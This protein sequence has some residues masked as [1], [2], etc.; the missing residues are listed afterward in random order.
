MTITTVMVCVVYSFLSL[1]TP[2]KRILWSISHL[3]F[4]HLLIRINNNIRI[5]YRVVFT[6]QTIRDILSDIKKKKSGESNGFLKTCLVVV[7]MVVVVTGVMRRRVSLNTARVRFNPVNLARKKMNYF[8]MGNNNS[9]RPRRLQQNIL[10]FPKRKCVYTV[11]EISID[12]VHKS[13]L[14]FITV[15]YTTHIRIVYIIYIHIYTCKI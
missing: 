13:V 5:I 14:F 1:F 8:V 4:I 11:S 9:V 15:Q 10:R 6:R 7:V 2:T 12:P 3:S